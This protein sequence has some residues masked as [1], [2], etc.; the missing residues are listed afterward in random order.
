MQVSR[1]P[2]V[3]FQDLR[4]CV[5]AA[6]SELAVLNVLLEMLLLFEQKFDLL[7]VYLAGA[8]DHLRPLVRHENVAAADVGLPLMLLAPPVP[9]KLV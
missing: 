8:R 3:G 1:E 6:C 4:Q 9:Q 7:G 2:A 5:E